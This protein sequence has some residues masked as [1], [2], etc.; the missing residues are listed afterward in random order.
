MPSIEVFASE[1]LYRIFAIV[2][3]SAPLAKSADEAVFGV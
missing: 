1:L 3:S 2:S